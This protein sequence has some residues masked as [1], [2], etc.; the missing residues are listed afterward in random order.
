MIGSEDRKAAKC[1]VNAGSD[2][3]TVMKQQGNRRSQNDQDNQDLETVRRRRKRG[4]G[5]L[6]AALHKELVEELNPL[7]A[8]S[9]DA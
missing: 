3:A 5:S 4:G 9:T 2:G 1:I 6:N 7:A 8:G